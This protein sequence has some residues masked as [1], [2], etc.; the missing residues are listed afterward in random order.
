M[1]LPRCSCGC[2]IVIVNGRPSGSWVQYFDERGEATFSNTKGLYVVLSEV[3]WCPGCGKKRD[4][5]C[6]LDGRAVVK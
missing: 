4:D 1:T 5:L 6:C 2:L 3:V